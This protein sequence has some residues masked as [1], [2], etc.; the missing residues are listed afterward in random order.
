VRFEPVSATVIDCDEEVVDDEECQYIPDDKLIEKYDPSGATYVKTLKA[1]KRK[2]TP[3][4]AYQSLQQELEIVKDS[5]IVYRKLFDSIYSTDKDTGGSTKNLK[6]N[7]SKKEED[8]K[9]REQELLERE[10][11]IS[12]R[13]ESLKRREQELLMKN[14][15]NI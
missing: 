11:D 5:N 1:K 8:L 4:S 14:N 7:K 10:K 6:A 15:N 2:V 12:Q 3:L 13:E 9:K